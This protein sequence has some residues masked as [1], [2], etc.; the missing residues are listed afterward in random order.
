MFSNRHRYQLWLSIYSELAIMSMSRYRLSVRLIG[1]LLFLLL[2]F[3]LTSCNFTPPQKVPQPESMTLRQLITPE[4][5]SIA[6]VNGKEVS[7]E[8]FNELYETRIARVRDRLQSIQIPPAI[9]FNIKVGIANSLI[10]EKLIEQL[11]IERN[12]AI[13]NTDIDIALEQLAD[14]FPNPKIFQRYVVNIPEG[15]QGLRNTLRA[16]LLK[17]R[18]AGVEPERSISDEKALKFYEQHYTSFN[19]PEHLIAQDILFL[20]APDASPE[21]DSAIRAE[22]Q[23]VLLKTA[24]SNTSFAAIARQDSEGPT[25]RSGGYLGRV[26][27]ESLDPTLWQTFSSLQKDQIS[28][29]VQAADGY[30]ILKL[31]RRNPEVHRSFEQV[32]EK[33]KTTTRTQQQSAHVAKLI[34]NLREDAEV[35]NYINQRYRSAFEPPPS[36]SLSRSK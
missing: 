20:V 18:L 1:G 27:Q 25:A 6:N 30:H 5:D 9:A 28:E 14:S 7:L 2:I 4:T 33:I 31:V 23:A 3:L 17:H 36:D 35:E 32:K 13:P 22:A 11:A 15:E 16:R 29:V 12:I 21:V 24:Q 34:S 8:R 19:I 10:D 26:T